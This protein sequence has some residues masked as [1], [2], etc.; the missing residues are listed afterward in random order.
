MTDLTPTA[1]DE[2]EI[3]LQARFDDRWVTQQG[4][5]SRWP[6][7]LAGLAEAQAHLSG[8]LQSRSRRRYRLV[9]RTIVTEVLS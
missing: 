1:R 9:R 4:V 8:H 7:T 6:D 5:G 3:R 2:T